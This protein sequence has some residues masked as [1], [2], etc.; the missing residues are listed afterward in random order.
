M[1][2]HGQFKC[3]LL[4][5]MVCNYLAT[6]TLPTS[7]LCND[8]WSFSS[9]YF[10]LNKMFLCKPF[11]AVINL[12]S[13]LNSYTLCLIQ[14]V[15]SLNRSLT[16]L[17]TEFIEPN[18]CSWSVSALFKANICSLL[19]RKYLLFPYWKLKLYQSFTKYCHHDNE[20]W[21]IKYNFF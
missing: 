8:W 4:L 11:M 9:F 13:W 12:S 14:Q 3:S 16:W 21:R 6:S 1:L 2:Q 20:K 18:P 17:Y 10:T 5:S 15:A 7:F 19:G